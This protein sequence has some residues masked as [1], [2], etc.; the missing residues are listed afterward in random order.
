VTKRKSWYRPW[1]KVVAAVVST[2]A[3]IVGIVWYFS[4]NSF[5]EMLGHHPS[6]HLSRDDVEAIVSRIRSQTPLE[7]GV[8]PVDSADQSDHLELSE[9]MRNIADGAY[10]E[11][12]GRAQRLAQRARAPIVQYAMNVAGVAFVLDG[13]LDSALF[14]FALSRDI[15]RLNRDSGSMA[16]AI[17]NLGLVDFMGGN[18]PSAVG[19]IRQAAA[20]DSAAADT[21]GWSQ[22]LC[23]LAP[24]LSFLGD[25]TAALAAARQAVRLTADARWRDEAVTT[26]LTLGETYYKAGSY[27]SS[28]VFV[29]RALDSL[30]KYPDKRAEAHALDALAGILRHEGK[31]DSALSLSLAALK[32][33]R[34]NK[35]W[36]G[37][38]ECLMDIAYDK[39]LRK[40][41]ISAEKLLVAALGTAYRNNDIVSIMRIW[42]TLGKTLKE[43]GRYR[44]SIVCLVRACTQWDRMGLMENWM[45]A[46]VALAA[47]YSRMDKEEF[48]AVLT[49]LK[50]PVAGVI[51]L[52][53]GLDAYNQWAGEQGVQDGD[54]L[55]FAVSADTLVFYARRTKMTPRNQHPQP[56]A[57]PR[58]S[59]GWG[60]LP[61]PAEHIRNR[62]Y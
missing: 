50:A 8:W 35:T 32:I 18:I 1:R 51:D 9:V 36:R 37:E 57:L 60:L 5:P 23:N 15:A 56:L 22:A 12:A 49:S 62:E 3:T 40:D 29:Q 46:W 7:L 28:R 4:G 17:M 30:Q 38:T 53:E 13:Q 34:I 10:R 21:T 16:M 27:E 31:L 58:S 6:G 59:R 52:E 42:T 25:R 24:F 45:E 43:R 19:R 2:V 41:Y 14:H 11:A 54:S 39:I 47:V 33:Y 48:R 20:V 44:T 61:M 55:G 26:W